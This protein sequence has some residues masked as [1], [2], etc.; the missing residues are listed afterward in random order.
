MEIK[1]KNAAGATKERKRLGRGQASGLGTTSGKGNKGQK[2][3]KGYSRKAG[4]EGGQ[5]PLYRRIPKR[6]FSNYP[7]KK[8]YQEVSIDLLVVFENG[9]NITNL[10][11]YEKGLIKNLDKPFKIL[12]NLPL[13]KSI[14]IQ[15]RTIM[16]GKKK[17]LFDKITENSKSI[18]EKAGGKVVLQ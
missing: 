7:F 17:L 9:S 10:D 16:K 2:S 11:L 1:L 12:G 15:L 4:F 8:E 14:T 13:D 5:M 18:I 3:R 6:G